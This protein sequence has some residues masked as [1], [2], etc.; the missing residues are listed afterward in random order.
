MVWVKVTNPGFL[1]W[2]GPGIENAYFTD[3]NGTE[4][5]VLRWANAVHG[6][7]PEWY[8]VSKHGDMIVGAPGYQSRRITAYHGTKVWLWRR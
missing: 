7:G 5:P 3:V 8:D 1:F 4:I 2:D 6:F